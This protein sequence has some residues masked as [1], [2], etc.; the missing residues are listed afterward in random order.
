M[1]SIVVAYKM[2]LSKKLKEKLADKQFNKDDES[3]DIN[4]NVEFRRWP[5]TWWQQ[6]SVLLRNHSEELREGALEQLEKARVRLRKVEMET[7]QFRKE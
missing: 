3:E 4:K 5:T 2:K 6:F 7:D 1:Q